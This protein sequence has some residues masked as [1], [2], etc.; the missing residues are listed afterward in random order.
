MDFAVGLFGAIDSKYGWMNIF[1]W[2]NLQDYQMTVSA[3]ATDAID[4]LLD[5]H[6][7]PLDKARDAWYYGNGRPQRHDPTGAA[8]TELGHEIDLIVKYKWSDHYRLRAGY[9]HF[10]PGDFIR[11]TGPSPA[12]DWVYVQCMHEF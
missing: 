12:A 8:G 6:F 1:A 5:Y 2:R 11:R 9:S 4:V 7:F 10:F 3:K